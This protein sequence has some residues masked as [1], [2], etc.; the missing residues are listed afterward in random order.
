MLEFTLL[1]FGGHI[2]YGVRPTERRKGYGT[3]MLAFALEKCHGFGIKK[4]LVTCDKSNN[5]SR[6]TI[7]K[8]GGIL[9]NEQ[10]EEN[11]NILQRCWICIDRGA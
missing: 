2:G 5:A 1:K 9:E 4:A 11:G 7:L 6:K 8:N 3:K 10:P